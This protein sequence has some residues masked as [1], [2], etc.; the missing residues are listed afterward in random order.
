MRDPLVHALVCEEIGAFVRSL[1]WQVIDI[2]PSPI[3]GGDGN[4][5]FLLGASAAD[6]KF[7]QRLPQTV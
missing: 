7:L 3:T 2:V 6:L 4:R 1:G 5:E